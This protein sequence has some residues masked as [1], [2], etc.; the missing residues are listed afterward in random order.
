MNGSAKCQFFTERAITLHKAFHDRNTSSDV[1]EVF[2][3]VKVGQYATNIHSAVAKLSV[4]PVD[5]EELIW[6][7][8]WLLRLTP[9]P[10]WE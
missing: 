10:V 7:L 4:L 8:A 6:L 2:A 3:F 9:W 1:F 5:N